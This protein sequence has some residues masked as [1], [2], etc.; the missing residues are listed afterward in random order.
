MLGS[1]RENTLYCSTSSVWI[2]S[3]FIFVFFFFA[4]LFVCMFY[5]SQWCPHHIL[6][7]RSVNLLRVSC[8]FWVCASG[9]FHSMLAKC[10]PEEIP[11]R[12]ACHLFQCLR[13]GHPRM[14]LVPLCI[15]LFFITVS[16]TQQPFCSITHGCREPLINQDQESC[17]SH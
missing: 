2:R 6:T 9:C 1:S 10:P 11:N 4:R 16:Q 3:I 5:S 7:T 13:R 17:W 12:K 15:M 8:H 14:S